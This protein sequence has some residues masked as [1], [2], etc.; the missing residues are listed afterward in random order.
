MG[1]RDFL[2]TIALV[3]VITCTVL[4]TII[5]ILCFREYFKIKRL[6][7]I[8]LMIECIGFIYD[9]LIMLIGS[10]LSDS[11]LKS[12]NI[13]RQI[14]HGILIPILIPFTGYA[15]QFR[16]DKLYKNWVITI[17]CIIIGLASA[18]A[19]KMEILEEF[20]KLKDVES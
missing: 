2:E 14:L 7:F 20:G 19:T 11:A 13:I 17:I 4:Y 8:L 5:F 15:L 18:I 3:S 6:V 16:R 10:K 9:G 12:T 1:F